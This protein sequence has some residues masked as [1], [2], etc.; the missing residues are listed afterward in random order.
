MAG[1]EHQMTFEKIRNFN[2]K[3]K[4]TMSRLISLSVEAKLQVG[5]RVNKQPDSVGS[6]CITITLCNFKELEDQCNL[7]IR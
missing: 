3:I 2:E 7:V 4:I 1:E 6:I 5:G